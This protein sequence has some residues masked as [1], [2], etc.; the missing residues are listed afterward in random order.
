MTFYHGADHPQRC[1]AL[2]DDLIGAGKQ[3]SGTTM[4]SALTVLRLMTARIWRVASP[5]NRPFLSFEDTA[6]IEPAWWNP[7]SRSVP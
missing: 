6:R 2:L 5:E 4:P 3:V 1:A 7:S